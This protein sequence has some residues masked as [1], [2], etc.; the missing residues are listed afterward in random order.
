MPQT[1]HDYTLRRDAKD[2]ALLFERVVI[3]IRQE[4][5]YQQLGERHLHLPRH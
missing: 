3:Y 2:E 4:G 5:Y 1:P